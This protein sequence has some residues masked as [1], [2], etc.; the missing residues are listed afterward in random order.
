MKITIKKSVEQEIELPEFP[1]YIKGGKYTCYKIYSEDECIKLSNF[2]FN[3]SIQS[4]YTTSVA[5]NDF[6]NSEIITEEEF[7]EFYKMVLTKIEKN[8]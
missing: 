7:K 3:P 8:L 2:D 1:F 4:K 6:E 5:L